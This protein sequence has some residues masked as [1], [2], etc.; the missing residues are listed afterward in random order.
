MK[1]LVSGD[2][3]PNKMIFESAF[4]PTFGSSIKVLVAIDP[5][6]YEVIDILYTD[7]SSSPFTEA[8]SHWYETV[9]RKGKQVW[10]R[11]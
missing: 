5:I 10:R 11:S 8:Y 4:V 1:S 7:G 6:S 9:Y 3:R 2:G